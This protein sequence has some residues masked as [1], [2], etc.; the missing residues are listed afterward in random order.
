[1]FYVLF[2]LLIFAVGTTNICLGLVTSNKAEEEM[3]WE[4]LNLGRGINTEIG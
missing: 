4:K 1:M 3:K 2:I